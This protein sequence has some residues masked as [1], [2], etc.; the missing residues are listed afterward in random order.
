MH[1]NC[2]EFDLKIYR[3]IFDCAKVELLEDYFM[4]TLI[5]SQLI[6]YKDHSQFY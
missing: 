4:Y 5:I 1:F 6:I 2:A 3:R